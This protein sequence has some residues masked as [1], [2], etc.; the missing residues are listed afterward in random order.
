MYI[1]KSVTYCACIQLTHVDPY[2][3]PSDIRLVEATSRQ[4]VFQ[5]NAVSPSCQFVQYL[6]RANHHCGQCPDTTVHTT[7]SCTGLMINGQHCMF[8]LQAHVCDSIVGNV[9]SNVLVALRGTY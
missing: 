6:I 4:L 7:A 3:P 5:W 9:S 2:P 8:A 1:D